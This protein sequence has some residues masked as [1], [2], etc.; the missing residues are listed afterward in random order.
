MNSGNTEFN[1]ETETFTKTF[2]VGRRQLKGSW[3]LEAAEDMKALHG[4][5]LEKELVH[6]IGIEM[7]REMAG[8]Y[9]EVYD[10]EDFQF[11]G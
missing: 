11:D 5:D 9:R 1:P 7:Q 10:R 2:Q 4:V 8:I 6:L 3:T